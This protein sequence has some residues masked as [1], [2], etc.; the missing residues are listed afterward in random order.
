MNTDH[1]AFTTPSGENVYAFRIILDSVT[2]GTFAA[3]MMLG[4][5]GDIIV[6][7]NDF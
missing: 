5:E 7:S 6:T 3:A 2:N 4:E 1:F